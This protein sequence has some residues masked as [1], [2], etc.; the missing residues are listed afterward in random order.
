MGWWPA[1][2]KGESI[3]DEPADIVASLFAKIA[4]ESMRSDPSTLTLA[5]LMSYLE[6]AVK[7]KNSSFHYKIRHLTARLSDGS[8][9]TSDARKAKDR[10]IFDAIRRALAD[11]HESYE[12]AFERAPTLGEILDS[13]HF[14][15]GADPSAYLSDLRG[16]T[17]EELSGA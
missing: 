15:I 10:T 5:Q 8:V 17:I 3:G 4:D 13:F 2:R 14:V 7:Q 9:V 16:V 11:I 6:R 1:G 12:Q